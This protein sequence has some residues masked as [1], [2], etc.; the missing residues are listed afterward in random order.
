MIDAKNFESN[1]LEH[2]KQKLAEYDFDIVRLYAERDPGKYRAVEIL[3]KPLDEEEVS[4][5]YLKSRE[6][7][8]RFKEFGVS[9]SVQNSGR[10][11]GEIDMTRSFC[12]R[13]DEYDKNKESKIVEALDKLKAAET[14]FY[15]H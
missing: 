9:L 14:E 12:V 7:A 8:K 3:T 10:G 13:L 5:G 1:F 6:I 11:E 4:L 15:G 2:N